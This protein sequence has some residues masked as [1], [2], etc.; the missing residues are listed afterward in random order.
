MFGLGEKP[1]LFEILLVITEIST[2]IS[3][4]GL[5]GTMLATTPHFLGWIRFQSGGHISVEGGVQDLNY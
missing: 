4:L 1:V 5:R 2:H 3:Y